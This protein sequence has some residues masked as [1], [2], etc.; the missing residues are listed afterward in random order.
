MKSKN[1]SANTKKTRDRQ[2]RLLVVFQP[3]HYNTNKVFRIQT[4][5]H[6]PVRNTWYQIT[7]NLH[8][9]VRRKLKMR[10][11][12]LN[13][14]RENKIV[15]RCLIYWLRKIWKSF[16]WKKMV[17]V[18]SELF[19]TRFMVIKISIR[20]SENI[21]V[22]IWKLTNMIWYHFG[23]IKRRLLISIVFWCKKTVYG[24][25]I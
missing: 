22:F 1:Y 24:A 10:L 15:A 19:R 21:A 8:K 25:V 2:V 5:V 18:Y 20:W 16:K 12:K 4:K 14:P 7:N 23:V 13:S 3:H 11:K 17:T 6:A 9:K